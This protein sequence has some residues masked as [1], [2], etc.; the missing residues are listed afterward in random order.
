ME[1]LFHR[2]GG[3]VD[4]ERAGSAGEAAALDPVRIAIGRPFKY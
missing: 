3:R 1:R 4:Y 2:E